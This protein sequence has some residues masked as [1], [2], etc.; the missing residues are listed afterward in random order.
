MANST[1]A[2]KPVPIVYGVDTLGFILINFRLDPLIPG[3]SSTATFI[4]VTPD[5][6][7]AFVV[8]GALFR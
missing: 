7:G 1:P 2:K 5:S 4:P 3:L 8:E 6:L